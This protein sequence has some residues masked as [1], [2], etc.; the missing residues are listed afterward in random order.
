LRD[1]ILTGYLAPGQRL[2]VDLLKEMLGT[3][4]S[5]IR[6]ALSLLTSDQLVDRLD[7]RGFRVSPVSVGQFNEI[8][9]LRCALE[10]MALSQSIAAADQAWEESLVLAHHRLTRTP[11]DDVPVFEAHHKTFHMSLLAACVSPILL[12]FC[13]QLY[14]LN[15]RYRYLAGQS[16]GYAARDVA[17][18]HAAILHAAVD[19]DTQKATDELIQHYRRTGE[20]L[21]ARL[22][23]L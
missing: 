16:G 13:D 1:R 14:D 10:S 4:A 21:S 3:G 11:R 8:L 17:S 5:P 20:F 23:R 19:R 18:E 22:A 6:E 7:Q 12:K 15:I 2:K 9:M